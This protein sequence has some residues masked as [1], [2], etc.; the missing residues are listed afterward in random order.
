MFGLGCGLSSGLIPVMENL[1]RGCVKNL[2]DVEAKSF[3]DITLSLFRGTLYKN[4]PKAVRLLHCMGLVYGNLHTLP[5]C[6]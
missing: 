5:A 2:S 6:S 3:S 1:C 4:Y